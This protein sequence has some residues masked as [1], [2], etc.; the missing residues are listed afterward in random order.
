MVA[1][2][3]PSNRQANVQDRT[4]PADTSDPEARAIAEDLLARTAKAM[5]AHDFDALHACFHL[6]IT[7]ETPNSKMVL[8]TVEAHRTL[9]NTIIEGYAS[10]GVTDLVR[11]CQSAHFVTPTAIHSLHVSHVMADT[12]R[13]EDS[14]PTLSRLEKIGGIWGI[15]SA[16]YVATGTQP[17]IRAIE[18]HA[19]HRT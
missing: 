18:R 7:V 5:L 9:V 12:Q 3:H 17:V 13:L 14:M 16:Q 8:D 19:H 6:P 2:V 15:T 11:L 10:R 4:E 1:H